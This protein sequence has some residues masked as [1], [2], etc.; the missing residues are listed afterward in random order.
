[1]QLLNSFKKKLQINCHSYS[2]H[3]DNSFK[4]FTQFLGF[5]GGMWKLI[6]FVPLPFFLLN[7][8]T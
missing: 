1:M 6:I 5:K 8:N 7:Q 4:P 2:D 3:A